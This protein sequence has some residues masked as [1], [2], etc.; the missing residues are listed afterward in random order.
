MN[1]ILNTYLLDKSDVVVPMDRDEFYKEQI[2]AFNKTGQPSR[3]VEIVNVFI[4][5]KSGELLVQKRSYSKSHNAG[6]LDKSVGGHV[7][8]GDT[9][10]FS[11]MVETVQELQAPSVVLKD[12]ADFKK[13]YS[14]FRGYLSTIAVVQQVATKICILDKVIRGEK[15]KIA[16]KINLYFGVYGGSVRPADREAKGVILYSLDELEKEMKKIP[17][18]FTPDIH[19]LYAEFGSEMRKFLQTAPVSLKIK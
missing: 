4:F 8:F 6:L 11:V 2:A 14:L 17:D 18:A 13:A 7:R 12:F 19:F 10:D 1:E 3:A 16:N 15:V 5:N 9:P